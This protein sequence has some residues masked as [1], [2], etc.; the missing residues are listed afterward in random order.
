MEIEVPHS[1]ESV[2]QRPKFKEEMKL[3]KKDS[4]MQLIQ[5]RADNEEEIWNSNLDLSC[6]KDDSTR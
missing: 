4:V 5:G 3:C 6:S 2:F 1:T